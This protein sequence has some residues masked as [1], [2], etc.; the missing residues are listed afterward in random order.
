MA[1][2]KFQAPR[3][4]KDILPQEEGYWQF[5]HNTFTEVMGLAGFGRIQTPVFEPTEL[6]ERGV[7]KSSDIVRKEMYTFKDKSDNSLTLRPEGT[8]PVMRAYIEHGMQSWPQSVKLAY[9]ESMYR[10]ERPQ[11]G[12][13]R[14]HWQIGAELIGEQAPF[15]DCQVIALALRI[16][17]KL[18]LQNL[19]LQLNSLGDEKCRPK[20]LKE[21]VK[22]LGPHQKSLCEDC[23]ERYKLNPLRVLDCKED[24]C[25]AIIAESPTMLDH[26]C[27]DCHGHF[28]EVLEYLDELDI[29]YEIN[30]RI[31]RGLDYYTRTLFEVWGHAGSGSALGGGG[32]YDKLMKEIGGPDIPAVGFGAGVERLIE[33]LKLQKVL[34]P[35]GPR[36]QVFVANLGDS[37]RKR[38]YKIIEHLL[39]EGV[40]AVGKLDKGS[41]KAQL[42]S[43][44][45]LGVPLAVIIGQKEVFDNTAIIRDMKS[46]A[47]EVA[48]LN[49]LAKKIKRKL[50]IAAQ[51]SD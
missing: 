39:S 27:K 18:G 42:R 9:F 14:E 43:A 51:P 20:Y 3:G 47:Q 35:P 13:Y 22:Y 33:E 2:P 46:G 48:G 23:R 31:V 12:R 49:V 28:K 41:I 40:G 30:P 50:E 38:C 34:P 1:N 36:P 25:Q 19:S 15:A 8:A 37:A 26:L 17:E 5:V 24:K 29:V 44:D 7:G 6:F 21:L 11:A 45:K 4:T 32:R 16:Y 10:Y